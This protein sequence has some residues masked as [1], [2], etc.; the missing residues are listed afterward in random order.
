MKELFIDLFRASVAVAPMFLIL[1]PFACMAIGVGAYA[2]FLYFVRPADLVVAQSYA[3]WLNFN[4]SHY[5]EA[6]KMNKLLQMDFPGTRYMIIRKSDK[7]EFVV[8]KCKHP[9]SNILQ[10]FFNY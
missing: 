5:F 2:L 4:E 6:Q 9:A 3:N 8:T 7:H 10:P 1:V